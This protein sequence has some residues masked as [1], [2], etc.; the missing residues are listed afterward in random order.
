MAQQNVSSN[1]K[2]PGCITQKDSNYRVI[3]LKILAGNV[4]CEQMEKIMDI[5]RRYGRGYI[6]LTTRLNIEIPWVHADMLEAALGELVNAGFVV[7]ST[8]PTVRAIVSCKGTV[9]SHGLGDTQE[10]CR[11]LDKVYFGTSTPSKFK[12]GIVGCPNNCGKAQLN[13]LGFMGQCIPELDA[14]KCAECELC[15]SV[16]KVRAI[17]RTDEGIR[18]DRSKCVNCGTCVQQ[19]ATGAL[20]VESQGFAVFLGGKFGRRYKIGQRIGDLYTM[21]EI[22]ELT[23]KILDYYRANAMP[24]ER[25]GDMIERLS[26]DEVAVGLGMAPKQE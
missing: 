14:D 7:G 3:R 4:D 17:E 16:C 9:C 23:G 5:A 18:I 6:S 24:G 11:R 26:L 15:I 19:C 12:I 22:V 10:L 8:G 1:K 25:F 2:I 13:D 21:D 20:S